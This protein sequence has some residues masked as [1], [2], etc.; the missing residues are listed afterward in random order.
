MAINILILEPINGTVLSSLKSPNIFKESS[1]AL[2]FKMEKLGFL[3][4]L[5]LTFSK[6]EITVK[7]HSYLSYFKK[8]KK[9][10]QTMVLFTKQTTTSA[11]WWS[12]CLV[13][14]ELPG[15]SNKGTTFFLKYLPSWVFYSCLTV[16][17]TEH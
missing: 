14:N 9:K 11:K 12:H 7:G 16:L 13:G 3:Q 6:D 10:V 2:H 5:P 1:Y 8:K 15:S 4:D 17:N